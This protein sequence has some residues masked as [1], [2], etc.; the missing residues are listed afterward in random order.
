MD[1]NTIGFL[2]SSNEEEKGGFR[3][4]QETPQ[5]LHLGHKPPMHLHIPYGKEYV[6]ICP[7]CQKK[8]VLRPPQITY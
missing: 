5:C 2:N 4:I 1:I 6:H 8:T 7:G 3:D